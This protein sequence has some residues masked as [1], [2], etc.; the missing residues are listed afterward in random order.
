VTLQAVR[1]LRVRS[2]DAD[3]LLEFNYAL[4]A[5]QTRA[6]VSL[7]D[8]LMGDHGRRGVEGAELGATCP[9]LRPS[10][11]PEFTGQEDHDQG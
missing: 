9:L 10:D 4:V 1:E 7:I 3:A 2:A 5:H 6:G 11:R 8:Q